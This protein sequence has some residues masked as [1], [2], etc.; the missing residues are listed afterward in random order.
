MSDRRMMDKTFDGA[1]QEPEVAKPEVT[2]VKINKPT[3]TI[4]TPASAKALNLKYP[5]ENQDYYKA[6]IRFSLYEINPYTIDKEAASQIADMPFLFKSKNVEKK[7]QNSESKDAA[8]AGANAPNIAK[9]D[10]GLSS[11]VRAQ[12]AAASP[13]EK[14]SQEIAAQR[15][16]AEQE[17]T[18]TNRDLSL[19]PTDLNQHVTLYFPPNVANVD[20][21]TYSNANLGPGGATALAASR[22]QG[23]L[24]GSVAKGVTEG[25]TDLFNLLKGDLASAEA[26]QVAATRAFNKL[27]SGG[28]QNFTRVALQKII[29]PNTRS[30]FEGPTIRKFT[31]VFKLIATSSKEATEIQD[32]IRKF[33]SE[34]YPEAIEIGGL[35]IGF[36]F[37]KMF[38]IQYLYNG[39]RN[40]KLP[41]PLMCYLEN[42]TTTYNSSNMVFHADGQPTEVDLSLTFTEFRALTKKDILEGSVATNVGPH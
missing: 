17:A 13:F 21:V 20:A 12:A 14:Q 35:P 42:A 15:A 32:I 10:P 18:A 7:G 37:P 29:N 28:I 33:R 19:N 6:G 16:K 34:M 5:L 8:S 22:N 3:E 1:V 41:Q 4:A 39:V 25:V 11:A 24:I 40:T 27:P 31:F 26:A 9:V 30:M 2:S 23:S 36:N 38:K